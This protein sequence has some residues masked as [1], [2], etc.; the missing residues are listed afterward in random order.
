VR[1]MGVI[2]SAVEFSLEETG[3]PRH[4][5]GDFPEILAAGGPRLTPERIDS[6]RTLGAR[7]AVDGVGSRELVDLYLSLARRALPNLPGLLEAM[8]SGDV[9]GVQAAATTAL[10]HTEEA[11]AALADG[12][13]ASRA[14]ADRRA[15]SLRREFIDDLLSGGAD[16]VGLAERAASLGLRLLGERVV[17]VVRAADRAMTEY[18]PVMRSVERA[19]AGR[20]GAAEH[21]VATRTGLLV[22]VVPA[23][24]A[25]AVQRREIAQYLRD[26]AHAAEPQRVWRVA[27]SRPRPGPGGIRVSWQEARDALELATVLLPGAEVVDAAEVGG[28]QLLLRDRDAVVALAQEVFAPLSRVRGGPEPY[29][30]V[31]LALFAAGGNTTAAARSLHL[32]V[33]ATLYRLERVQRLTGYRLDNPAHRF[34]LQVI[35]LAARLGGFSTD[36][37]S[38]PETARFT[39]RRVL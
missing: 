10:R 35:A 31:L 29:V 18:G 1:N 38:H 24:T 11:V 3:L 6:F 16:E 23:G 19:L 34:T 26:L 9:A 30:E 27:I 39:Q 2:A 20:F 37:G 15:E 17:V 5:L 32:S 28:Y 8:D 33:R 25:G 14:Q 21:L 22:C 12:Y 36:P 7:A 13:A 4:L